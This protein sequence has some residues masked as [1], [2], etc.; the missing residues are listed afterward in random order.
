MSFLA[1]L[2]AIG[3]SRAGLRR[4]LVEAEKGL[5]AAISLPFEAAETF[6]ETQTF[7]GETENREAPWFYS[8]GPRPPQLEAEWLESALLIAAAENLDAVFFG[9]ASIES[10]PELPGSFEELFE[11]PWRGWTFFSSRVFSERAGRIEKGP[12]PGRPLVTK[13]IPPGGLRGK[14]EAEEA[15]PPHRR[16]P[17][18]LD[19]KPPREL[20]IEINDPLPLEWPSTSPTLPGLLITAPFLA[21]GG[22]EHTLYESM[23]ILASEY[24]IFFLTFAEHRRELDDR[25]PDFRRLSPRLLSLGDWLH[26]D[27]MP[28]VVEDLIDREQITIWYNANGSTLFYDF[29]PRIAARFPGLRI[30]DH[31]YD[32]R[33][34]YIEAF[35]GGAHQD[36]IDAV[37]AEN[38][39]IAETLQREQGWPSDRVPVVWPCGRPR[40]ALSSEEHRDEIRLR[41]RRELEIPPEACLFLTAARI[42]EQKRPLDLVRLASRAPENCFFLV[43]GGGPLA[44]ALDDAIFASKLRNICRLDFRTDIPELILAADA[45]LLV[46][47][48]E[49]LPVFALECMQLGRPFIGTR[50]GDLGRLLEESGGGICSGEPG[51]LEALEGAVRIMADADRRRDYAEKAVR[52]G[53]TFFPERCAAEMKA[54]FQGSEG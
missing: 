33:V 53:K 36:W 11:A 29:G 7:P 8:P 27:A 9:D 40:E 50:V 2:R 35:A 5:P 25:R 37:V 34:G 43:V 47:D 45:G 24:R 22:A 51:D 46:S 4:C 17:Y 10:P 52:A 15:D 16:G 39:P 26:P 44:G 18:L 48:F 28:A 20:K 6:R 31:L 49:G 21:R 12:D 41:L 42:H 1:K 38:H 23:R 3:R 13:I 19:R 14:H 54:V 32:H 30:I